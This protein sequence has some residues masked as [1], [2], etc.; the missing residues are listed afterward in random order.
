MCSDMTLKRPEILAPGGSIESIETA[1]AAGADAVYVG[2]GNLNARA[3]AGNL[4]EEQLAG[5]VCFCHEAGTRVYVTLN[6]PVTALNLKETA[7]VMALCH[8]AGADALIVRDPIVMK[9]ATAMIPDIPIHASTQAGVH[10]VETA[11]RMAGLG[12]RRLILA[13]ECSRKDII[14]IREALPDVEIEIFAFGAMCFGVSGM[15]MMG[16][17]VSGRSGNYG[18]C[19]Q[20]CRLPY[21][22]RDGRPLGYVFSMKDLDLVPHIPELAGIGVDSLKIEGRLKTPAWVGCVTRWLKTA[23]DRPVPG[24]TP[25]EYE[26]F[27]RDVSVMYSRPRTD[28]YFTG[29]TDWDNLMSPGNQTHMG[30]DVGPFK[31][32]RDYSGTAVSFVTPVDINIRDG[33]LIKVVDKSS[34]DGFAYVPIGIRTLIDGNGR[35]AIRIA[36]GRQVRVPLP[37]ELSGRTIAGVA[38]HSAD[39]VRARYRKVDR[40][41]PADV[42]EGRPPAPAWRRVT[43]DASSIE[44]EMTIGRCRAT[45]RVPITS[46]AATGSGLD[47]ERLAKY[48]DADEYSIQPGLFINPSILKAARRELISAFEGAREAEL[49]SLET[50]LAERMAAM[51]NHFQPS[52]DELMKSGLAALTKVTGLKAGRVFTSAGDGFEIVPGPNVTRIMAFDQETGGDEP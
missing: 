36:E 20:S 25:Q 46:E 21:F 32:R 43:V 41:V 10:N 29:L 5:L 9:T 1:V 28:G 31:S 13:R 34:P 50:A 44:A 27:N 18:S 30:L 37:E 26:Q 16:H 33:L 19:C 45:A 24:L 3:R 11:R 2:V 8:Q 52:D 47:Q 39:S 22:D 14:E 4:R 51:S 48:F 49:A 23:V 6:I 17:H 35:T 15:C 42:I 38:I 12:C 7:R 40:H